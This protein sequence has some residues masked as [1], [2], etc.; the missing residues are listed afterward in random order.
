[1]NLAHEL[2][3]F[4]AGANL[5]GDR[6]GFLSVAVAWAVGYP[7]AFAVLSYLVVKA[8]ELPLGPYLR[9]AWG[10]VGCSLGA[11]AAGRPGP[12]QRRFAARKGRDG[13]GGGRFGHTGAIERDALVDVVPVIAEVIA[14]L[15]KFSGLAYGITISL[16]TRSQTSCESRA[17]VA[18]AFSEL[19]ACA[20]RLPR[21]SGLFSS[22]T[23]AMVA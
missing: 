23:A 9:G 1:M 4:V 5:F 6:L 14:P 10:I 8:V 11:L 7:L 3:T 17:V 21:A 19:T 22:M 13:V 12:A 16:P 15:T 18:A 20:P 2:L